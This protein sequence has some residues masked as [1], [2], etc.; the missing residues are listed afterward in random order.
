MHEQ[1][2]V[3]DFRIKRDFISHFIPLFLSSHLMRSAG[4]MQEFPCYAQEERVS[5]FSHMQN[6]CVPV[7]NN[8]DSCLT[9]VAFSSQAEFLA[10]LA[11][12]EVNVCD[13]A[14]RN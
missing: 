9:C 5:G 7:M 4:G 3:H 10:S 8:R 11:I 6:V 12:C 2:R 13:P 1:L 14:A